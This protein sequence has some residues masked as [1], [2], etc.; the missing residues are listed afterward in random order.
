MRCTELHSH[1]VRFSILTLVLCGFIF[2]AQADAIETQSDVPESVDDIT[3][4]NGPD[5]DTPSLP[6]PEKTNSLPFTH[7]PQVIVRCAASATSQTVLKILRELPFVTRAWEGAVVKELI[8]AELSIPVKKAL[9]PLK[10]A[11]GE[12]VK[13]IEEDVLVTPFQTG[14]FLS[15]Q[16]SVSNNGQ[17]NNDGHTGTVDADVGITA[18]W[19]LVSHKMQI[20]PSSVSDRPIV[21]AVVDSGVDVAHADITQNLFINPNEL[22][23][24][25][26]DNDLNGVID[27][28][29]GA[30]FVSD[31]SH[32]MGDIYSHGQQTDHFGHGTRCAGIIAAYGK[33]FGMMPAKIKI[34]PVKVIGPFG[35]TSGDVA[36]GVLYAAKMGVDVINMSLGGSFFS[37]P[38]ND[39]ISYAESKGILVVAAAGNSGNE[40][41]Y[42][43][44]GL[45]Q[46]NI[47]AVASTNN[48]DGL[49]WNS[50]YGTHVDIAAPGVAILSLMSKDSVVQPGL[51]YDTGSGTSMSAPIVS[52]AAALLKFAYPEFDYL[53][54]KQ[55]LLDTADIRPALLEK[56]ATGGRLNAFHAITGAVSKPWPT[57]SGN[58]VKKNKFR[59]CT[60]KLHDLPFTLSYKKADAEKNWCIAV[61]GVKAI[62]LKLTNV[63]LGDDELQITDKAGISYRSVVSSSASSSF[64][65]PLIT[66]DAVHLSIWGNKNGDVGKGV[67]VK[68][69]RVIE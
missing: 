9:V 15:Q 27:D 1:T 12:T 62:K 24:D 57:I 52:G 69:I 55:R 23:N 49:A 16:W 50:T 6:A 42:Y 40:N 19:E 65:T 47:I 7:P 13:Y 56:V 59:G 2:T 43:P 54:I 38:L 64:W 58:L 14:E 60:G 5:L 53:Q 31:P 17:A 10:E 35:G 37:Q 32:A 66:G 20:V 44:A 68:L 3:T 45:P 11:L 39:A 34:L 25:N 63:G 48:R 30:N 33:M 29:Q 28:Y 22:Q 41:I 46:A 4:A 21:V 61:E 51:A 36:Q 26:K 67:K 8:Q 18:A